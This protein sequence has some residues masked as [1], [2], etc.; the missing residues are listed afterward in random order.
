[1]SLSTFLIAILGVVLNALAQLAIKSG[2]GSLQDIDIKDGVFA[3]T[4]R[5]AFNPGILTGLMMYV[6]SVAVWI[7]VLSKAEVGVAYPLLSIGY[8]LNIFLAAW[9]F[10][11][12]ITINKLLG[13]FLIVLGVYVL[14]R[15]E[16]VL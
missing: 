10:G 7:Y 4:L 9:F 2:T 8:V 14:T 6:V 12:L 16:Q 5:I 15:V 11:E 13:I 3:L 1:M